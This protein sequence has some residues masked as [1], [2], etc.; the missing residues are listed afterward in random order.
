[1]SIGAILQ[2][3]LSRSVEQLE[4]HGSEQ[5]AWSNHYPR[6]SIAMRPTSKKTRSWPVP[7]AG[8]CKA[9]RDVCLRQK[10][11]PIIE[12]PHPSR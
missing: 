5:A 8:M 1:M 10:D 7:T 12:R 2:T 11:T 9:S 6:G 4:E 3:G